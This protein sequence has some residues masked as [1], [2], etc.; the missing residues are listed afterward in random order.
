MDLQL[1]GKAAIVTGASS[2]IGE[3][4][5]KM[6]VANGARVVLVGRNPERLRKTSEE[7]KRA[8]GECSAVEE[9]INAEGAARRIVNVALET[10]GALNIVVQNAG[11][12]YTRDETPVAETPLDRLLQELDAMFATHVRAPVAL[13]H[14]ALSHVQEQRPSIVVIG[15]NLAH[16]GA[17]GTAVY[18][19]SKA[20]IEAFARVLAVELAPRGIRVNT[21]AP[22]IV[23]TPMSEGVT[24][25]P[26]IEAQVVS[27]IPL[28]YLAEPEDIA[29][30]VCF[31]ASDHASRSTSGSTLL[32]DGAVSVA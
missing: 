6:L 15:S 17:P 21:V 11:I 8:G 28:G 20:A 10:Y 12:Y 9:D 16:Y 26:N 29:H 7:I 31:L 32:V 30:A 1:R 14:A 3:A 24:K 13:A 22:G 19:A 5:A 23:R 2:G 4:T 25:D 27:Q 18:A